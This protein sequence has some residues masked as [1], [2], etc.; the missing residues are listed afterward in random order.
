MLVAE[1]KVFFQRFVDQR[2]DFG[3][4]LRI[5]LRCRYRRGVKMTPE[6]SPALDPS[7]GIFPVAIS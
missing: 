4:K 1:A 6:I 3:R 2:F 7:K 5:D